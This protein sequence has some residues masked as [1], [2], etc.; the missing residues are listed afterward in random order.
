MRLFERILLSWV[1][2]VVNDAVRLLQGG[3]HH[4]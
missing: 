4:D 1:D 3:D 2:V